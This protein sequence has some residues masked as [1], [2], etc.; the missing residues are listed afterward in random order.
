MELSSS[1]TASW[2]ICVWCKISSCPSLF[3]WSQSPAATVG[4]EVGDHT[5]PGNRLSKRLGPTWRANAL[6][7]PVRVSLEKETLE[8]KVSIDRFRGG[9]VCFFCFFTARSIMDLQS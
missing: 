3:V 6:V 2:I 9:L 5:V 7:A 8:I 4:Q 1:S